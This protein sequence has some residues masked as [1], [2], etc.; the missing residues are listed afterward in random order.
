M[1]LLSL[2]ASKDGKVFT[3]RQGIRAPFVSSG[4]V[5]P[6]PVTCNPPPPIWRAPSTL[7]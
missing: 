2:R 4:S 3:H 6:V 7:N 5:M 1:V